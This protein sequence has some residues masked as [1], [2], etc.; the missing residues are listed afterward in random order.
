MVFC[1]YTKLE[2]D[3]RM[4]KKDDVL[5][6][7]KQKIAT[8]EIAQ[9][10]WISEREI[11]EMY[12]ISRTPVREILWNLVSLNMIETAGD[13]GYRVIKY[14]IED[15]IE[16][17]NARKA[18]EGECARLACQS[19]DP[20]YESRVQAL[21]E[22]LQ[23]ASE[24][25]DPARLVAIGTK[26]HRFIQEKAGNRYLN[27]FNKRICSL[28]GIIRNTT[29]GYRSIEQQSRVGHREILDALEKRDGI[30]CAQ[31]M[32]KHLHAT[33]VAMVEYDCNVLLGTGEDGYLFQ[34]GE[35]E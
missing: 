35:E 6:D 8:G 33:C 18:I 20:D 5:E 4:A 22:E 23:A 28:V 26:V 7:L 2:G 19:A 29:K 30:R 25:E 31:A 27:A 34:E 15:I 3:S 24:E 21:K 32:R 12:Q 14:T 1:W 16:I 17:F 10:A 9:G 11:G 13:R